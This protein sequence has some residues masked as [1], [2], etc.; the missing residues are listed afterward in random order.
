MPPAQQSRSWCITSFNTEGFKDRIEA[1]PKIKYAVWQLERCP[2]TG[3][4]HVQAYV[5]WK[6]GIR[7]A[8]AKRQIGDAQAHLEVRRGTREQARDYCTKEESRVEGPWTV[9]PA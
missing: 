7:L 6:A 1:Q 9:C 4:L 2:D 5:E 8:A 3:R